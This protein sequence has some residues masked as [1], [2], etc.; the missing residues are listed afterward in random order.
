[1]LREG[2]S[3]RDYEIRSVIGQGGFGIV[4][5]GRHQELDI[6]VAIKEYFPQELSVRQG[7]RIL[8]SKPALQASFEDGLTRFLNE[9]KQLERFRMCPN[10]VTCRDL[11]RANG[12]AYTVMEYIT[13]LPLS[14]LLEKR[15]SRG[16]PLTEEELLELILPLLRGLQTV[17]ESGVFHRD[18]KPSNILV[19]RDDASPIL[20][21][22][23]A[24]KHEISKHTKSFAPYTDG[25]AA[26]EQ[27]GEG[28]IGPW[29]D[30]YGLG[31]VMW[32]IIAGGNPPFV[33]PN[34]LNIQKR[35]F[36]LMNGQADPMPSACQLGRGRFPEKVLKAVDECLVPN[37]NSRVQNCGELLEKLGKASNGGPE[38]LRPPAALENEVEHS[39]SLPLHGQKT[40]EVEKSED[41]QRWAL[42]RLLLGKKDAIAFSPGLQLFATGLA[43]SGDITVRD[44]H[45]G[46]QKFRLQWGSERVASVAFSDDETM[47]VAVG[48]R[49]ARVWNLSTQNTVCGIWA[50]KGGGLS[51]A[52]SRDGSLVAVGT[53]NGD[54]VVWDVQLNNMRL[55]IR[56]H[57]KDWGCRGVTALAFSPAGDRLVSGTF[58]GNLRIWNVETGTEIGELERHQSRCVVDIVFM[59]DAKVVVATSDRIVR[60]MDVVGGMAARKAHIPGKWLLGLVRT[61]SEAMAISA[62]DRQ[63]SV[64]V[65]GGEVAF[66]GSVGGI[67]RPRRI[68]SRP[69]WRTFWAFQFPPSFLVVFASL[70]FMPV[71]AF[72]VYWIY[73]RPGKNS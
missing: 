30:I 17:H 28:G 63:I 49:T 10:I 6:D 27:V 48:K 68:G 13:G 54:I 52:F 43:A 72:A 29:T 26:L 61:S 38:V 58:S 24:A 7:G 71:L 5:R 55:H 2:V 35:A 14:T 39:S 66:I 3:L 32:R 46:G 47:L 59:D 60:M 69:S 42:P 18:I 4:Y 36:A 12:T 31:A 25:Y 65:P 22:F 67:T 44:V 50:L 41:V 70:L 34:P 33:P 8:P 53:G 73:I 11:F 21:D 20:I 9:A 40:P 16:E 51:A 19:R 57:R 56:G 62:T 23:G 15:E 45:S 1:M 37:V 64:R